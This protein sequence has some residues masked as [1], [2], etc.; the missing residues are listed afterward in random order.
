MNDTGDVTK[1]GQQDI[2]EEVGIAST[3]QEDTKRR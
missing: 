1:N 2:D 3:L